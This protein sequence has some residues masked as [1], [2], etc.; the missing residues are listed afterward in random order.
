MSGIIKKVDVPKE[1]VQ[2]NNEPSW[3]LDEGIPGSGDRPEWLESKFK[4]VKD[5]ANSYKELEKLKGVSSQAP[6][7]Y[8][9]GDYQ[10]L[11]DVQNPHLSDLK[12][13]AKELKLSQEAFKAIVDPF[14]AYHKSLMPNV[15]EEIAKL[16]KDA[17]TKI[18]TVNT[19]ASNHLSDK[20]LETLGRISQTADVFEMMDEIRQLH[21]QTQSKVP[22]TVQPTKAEIYRPEDIQN[23]ISA[24]YERYKSDGAY[25]NELNRKLKQAYGED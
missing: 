14:A 4:S 7:D 24:N 6:E 10:E 25:R 1:E 17:D 18:N 19:W 2:Q 12:N 5:L 13:K 9:W 3:Y 11:F 22:T 20:A 15:D 23:E 8:D 21:Y 16:G